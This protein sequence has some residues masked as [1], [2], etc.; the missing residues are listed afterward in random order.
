M[1]R[2][3]VHVSNS[4]QQATDMGT[5]EQKGFSGQ[6]LAISMAV[7]AATAGV[8]SKIGNVKVQGV[9]AGQGNMAAVHAAVQTRIAN[10]SASNMSLQTMARGA[11]GSEVRESG[12]TAAGGAIDGAKIKACQKLQAGCQ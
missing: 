11:I 8:A 4:V 10:G 9:S 2:G 3:Q 6:N 7:G 1:V 12:R 5:G